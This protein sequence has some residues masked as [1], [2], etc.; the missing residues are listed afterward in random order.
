[1][2]ASEKDETYWKILNAALQL[3][4]KKG[5]QKWTMSDLSRMT[6]VTRSLLYYYFGKSRLDIL[7]EAI[8]LVGEELFGLTEK[9]KELWQNGDIAEAVLATRFVIES[10]PHLAAFYFVHRTR[11]TDFGEALRSLEIQYLKKLK[12]FFPTLPED[13]LKGLFGLFF[14]LVFTPNLNESSIRQAVKAAKSI[15]AKLH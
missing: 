3:D 15:S 14:G 4:F 1:M 12:Q 7:N 11:Q 9:K 10:S 6:G 13:D 8:R 5:H 2:A